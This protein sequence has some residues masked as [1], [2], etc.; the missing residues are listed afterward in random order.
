MDGRNG[1]FPAGEAAV[2]D[3]LWALRGDFGSLVSGGNRE[4]RRESI[5]T[6]GH[7]NGILCRLIGSRDDLPIFRVF[8]RR[9]DPMGEFQQRCHSKKS[10]E[11]G[12]VSKKSAEEM[13]IGWILKISLPQLPHDFCGPE[14][15]EWIGC[16][17]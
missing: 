15:G 17:T 9:A 7:S 12:C 10:P 14:M 3:E 6:A 11:Q 2:I 13:T 4:F 1:R 8:L 16:V 5:A